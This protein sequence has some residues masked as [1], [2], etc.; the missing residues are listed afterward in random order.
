[1]TTVSNVCINKLNKIVK[2]YNDTCHGTI[3][4]KPTDVKVN[5]YFTM[6]LHDR[7]P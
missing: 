2:K 4:L 5:T 6:V 1:M 7:F 3:K